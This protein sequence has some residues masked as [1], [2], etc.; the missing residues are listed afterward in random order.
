MA[1]YD[2]EFKKRIVRMHL[3]EGR[4][5]R[6]LSEEYHVSENRIGYWLKKYREECSKNPAAQEEYDL[7]KKNL[8]LRKELEE[9]K[10][11]N[12]FLKSG[13]ILRTGNCLA[14]YRFIRE[15]NDTM[16]LRWLLKRLGVFPNA[17][18]N[19][20]KDR[21][22][23][24]RKRKERLLNCITE[25]YHERKGVP[26][27]R[28][29]SALRKNKGIRISSTT[30]HK[31]MNCELKLFSNVVEIYIDGVEIA[32]IF[33]K[34]EVPYCEQEEPPNLAGDYGHMPAKKLY[35]DLSEA[36]IEGSFSCDF[37]VYPVCCRW[38][39][40]PRCWSVTFHVRESDEFVWWY[41]FEHE[42]REWKYDLEFKFLKSDYLK[43]MNKLIEWKEQ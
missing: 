32:E 27:Y 38:C 5:I 11:E 1:S 14:A 10:K 35:Q 15:N 40:E 26:G 3:E 21:K 39:G 6:S 43:E 2:E 31:Y 13:S 7:M 16:G 25:T 12:E 18:Y 23:A 8:R 36:T 24:Y 34:I 37:G 29:M 4:T 22:A 17:Y 33:R 42:H 41:G 19:Y 28:L 30:C 9:A 20:L